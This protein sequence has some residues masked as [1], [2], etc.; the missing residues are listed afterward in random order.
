MKIGELSKL[1]GCEVVTIR[2]YE[3]KGLLPHPKRT[4]SNYRTYEQ[5]HAERLKFIRFCRSL[6]I[7]L[8]DIGKLLELRDRPTMAC[9]EVDDLIDTHILQIETRIAELQQLKEQLLTIRHACEG[10]RSIA[11]CEILKQ[12]SSG[13]P[14]QAGN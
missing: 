13:T 8:H 7:S 5:A 3:K 9:G 10:G 2:Y 11:S 12:L 6:D 4:G 1:T 14:A